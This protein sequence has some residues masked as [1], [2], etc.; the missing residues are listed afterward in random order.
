MQKFSERW[1]GIMGNVKI[2]KIKKNLTHT[3]KKTNFVTLNT[4]QS[5]FFGLDKVQ[6]IKNA[7]HQ[8]Q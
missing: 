4:L 2:R 1:N 6:D 8:K 7:V 3:K 5:I